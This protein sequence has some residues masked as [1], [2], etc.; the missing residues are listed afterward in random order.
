MQNRQYRYTYVQKRKSTAWVLRYFEASASANH[1]VPVSRPSPVRALV[2]TICQGL[3]LIFS[4]CKAWASS[5]AGRAPSRSCLFAIN[6]SGTGCNMCWCCSIWSSSLRATTLQDEHWCV[7][8]ACQLLS[9]YTNPTRNR[10]KHSQSYLVSAV[11]YKDD[12]LSILIV[13]LPQ[14]SVSTRARHVNNGKVKSPASAAKLIWTGRI[15]HKPRPVTYPFLICSTENP[16]VGAI[17]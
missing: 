9:Q 4:S 11:Y 10:V 16:T 12:S 17:S 2:A 14:T 15:N 7:M 3:S 13:F 5:D 1:S 6:N 8:Q